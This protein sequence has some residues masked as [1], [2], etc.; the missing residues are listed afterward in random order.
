MNRNK[1]VA[2]TPQDVDSALVD[3]RPPEPLTDEDRAEIRLA[4]EEVRRGEVATEEEV[5]EAF[6]RFR[7]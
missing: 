5:E 3:T 6:A 1:S 2:S 7:S 4:L